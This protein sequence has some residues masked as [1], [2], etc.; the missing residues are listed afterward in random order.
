MHLADEE[1]I[2]QL[3]N[4]ITSWWPCRP[5]VQEAIEKR[6]EIS[7][8]G[9]IIKLNKGCPWQDHLFEIEKEKA[10][11]G[12]LK[13]VV[14]P[15]N[16]SWSVVGI[17]LKGSFA[18]RMALKEEWRG[19]TDINVLRKLSGIEDMTYCHENGFIGG[20]DSLESVIKMAEI[21]LAN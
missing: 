21:S 10:L 16:G 12:K 8:T 11:E 14:F 9:E 18:L 3:Q 19:V 4:L 6:F 13:F 2:D 5:M 17:N 7:K 15:K 1:L 20:A